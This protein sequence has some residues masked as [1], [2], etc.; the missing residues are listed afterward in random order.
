MK[1]YELPSTLLA[2]GY[3]FAI[4]ALLATVAP[5]RSCRAE[6]FIAC[7]ESSKIHLSFVTV[8]INEGQF[9]FLIDSGASHNVLASG[10]ESQIEH[11]KPFSIIGFDDVRAIDKLDVRVSGLQDNT[12]RPFI[13]MDLSE[14]SRFCEFRVDGVLGIPFLQD[15][16]LDFTSKGVILSSARSTVGDYERSFACETDRFGRLYVELSAICSEFGP[17][18]N[19][20]IDTG[21]NHSLSLRKELFQRHVRLGNL[22]VSTDR[23]LQLIFSA[24]AERT[25]LS[26]MKSG[27]I[28]F[29]ECDLPAMSV[30][31]DTENLLGWTCLQR[32]NARVDF[33]SKRFYVK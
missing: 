21:M 7:R 31:I 1:I 5:P 12:N 19:A 6:E 13:L 10:I 2:L 33:K 28:A 22:S 26:S 16:T 18:E 23:E 27:K 32:L 17:L 14:V 15:K 20:M 4:A 8:K 30:D 3:T 11:S 9:T 24:S 25:V 29:E